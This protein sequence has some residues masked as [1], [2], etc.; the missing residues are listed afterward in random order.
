M[1]DILFDELA[2]LVELDDNED[3]MRGHMFRR[4]ECQKLDKWDLHGQESTKNVE[5]VVCCHNFVE[6]F[7]LFRLMCDKAEQHED[8]NDVNDE[9]IATPRSN[10]VEVR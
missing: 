8:G 3:T 7:S 2:E 6:F 1:A 10:H 4:S 5:N 9:R